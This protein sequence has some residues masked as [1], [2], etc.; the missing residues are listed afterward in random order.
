MLLIFFWEYDITAVPVGT[1]VILRLYVEFSK[2][3]P[4]V[5]LE[6]LVQLKTKIIIVL[7]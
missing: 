6:H 3:V 1:A 4:D 5:P 7:K 2:S